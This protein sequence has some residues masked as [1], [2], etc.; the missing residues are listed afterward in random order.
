MRARR[1][2]L[3]SRS[4]LLAQLG[5]VRARAQQVADA[6]RED[7]PRDRLG[8]EVR[9]ARLRRRGGSTRRR[10]GPSSSRPGGPRR[11]AAAR[12]S[13]QTWKP[14]MPGICT[15]SSTRSGVRSEQDRERGAPVL[16]LDDFDA[17]G[18][19]R[20]GRRAGAWSDRRPRPA[21][22]GVCASASL[23]RALR[24]GQRRERGAHALV[25]DEGGVHERLRELRPSRRG[26]AARSRARASRA[27]ARRAA[28]RS[29]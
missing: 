25:L 14:S 1:C 19:E 23:T 24:L 7:Q 21:R 5:Q 9:G 29:T 22:A 15:S 26:R 27:A 6:V 4:R 28:R 16:G 12:I 18:L 13:S 17:V 11:A 8:E 3:A 2:A 20:L 10:R